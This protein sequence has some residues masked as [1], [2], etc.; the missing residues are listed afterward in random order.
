MSVDDA[1]AAVI[2]TT[3]SLGVYDNT[4]FM[5]DIDTHTHEHT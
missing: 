4:Y 3:K 2:T 5:S 1:I